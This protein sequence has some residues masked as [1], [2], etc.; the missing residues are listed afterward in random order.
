MRR[1]DSIP[2]IIKH[3]PSRKKNQSTHD[4]P[5]TY[6]DSEN[7]TL[8]I[9]KQPPIMS[10]KNLEKQQHST[11]LAKQ[12]TKN[13]NSSRNQEKVQKLPVVDVISIKDLN[14]ILSTI[15]GKNL[16][17]ERRIMALILKYATAL[18]YK[19]LV[20][21]TVKHGK[22][23]MEKGSTSLGFQE[24]Q[25]NMTILKLVI[26]SQGR[27]LL[28]KY[29]ETFSAMCCD[30][31]D[32][33]YLFTQIN[34]KVMSYKALH[35]EIN[36]ILRKGSEL[37]QKTIKAKSLPLRPK[38]ITKKKPASDTEAFSIENEK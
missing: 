24:N 19:E 16:I 34:H 29:K 6:D 35:R 28:R 10:K 13:L 9:K 25:G 12:G 4:D 2:V 3:L 8:D 11:L 36:G 14:F 33:Q 32:D 7:T 26:N 17:K 37:L 15:Q 30:K 20:S 23:L 21:L 22:E 1:E 31:Q 5:P 18:H 27:H 38:V